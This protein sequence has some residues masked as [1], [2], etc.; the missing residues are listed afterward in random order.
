KFSNGKMVDVKRPLRLLQATGHKSDPLPKEKLRVDS[1]EALKIATTQPSLENVTLKSTEMRLERGQANEPI[2]KIQMWGSGP[3]A[4]EFETSL[5]DITISAADGK[6][7]EAD[8]KP[9]KVR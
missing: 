9:E 2:W 5:G 3:K 1:D 7:I 4:P 8:L 6:V